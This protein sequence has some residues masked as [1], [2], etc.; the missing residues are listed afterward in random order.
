MAKIFSLI[1]GSMHGEMREGTTKIRGGGQ[2][3]VAG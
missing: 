2:Q 1:V 3:G